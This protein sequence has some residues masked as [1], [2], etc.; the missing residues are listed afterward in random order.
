MELT[1]TIKYDTLFSYKQYV[2][3][4]IIIFSET[5][6]LIGAGTHFTVSKDWNFVD[7][8]Q[9]CRI[10]YVH[11]GQASY[12]SNTELI[13]LQKGY[14]YFFPPNLPFQ[15]Y[16]DLKNPLT[17]TFFDFIMW[18]PIIMD[19][20][21]C[22]D[23]NIFP[24]FNHLIAAADD[25]L[26]R[27]G[28]FYRAHEIHKNDTT[29][30]I[31]CLNSIIN[32]LPLAVPDIQYVSDPDILEALNQIHTNY[33]ANLNICQIASSLGYHEDSFIRKF[34]KT[35]HI[36]PYQ[37]I[38]SI[39]LIKAQQLRREGLTYAQISDAVGYTD[40]ASLCHAMKKSIFDNNL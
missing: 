15:A 24:C 25:I 30:L 32:C 5:V 18:P 37:Y 1:Y 21:L 36:T 38:K 9:T 4:V 17:H 26:S 29:P 19:H 7:T 2:R 6:L 28:V 23:T 33:P 35:M 27:T 8:V 20:V 16:S 11:D 31:C 39:R 13:T 34:K 12:H 10:Y 3:Q 22:I 14:L 40:A